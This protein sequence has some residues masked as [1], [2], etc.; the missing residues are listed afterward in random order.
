M[1]FL[2]VH[3][4][5]VMEKDFCALLTK[6]IFSKI[7]LSNYYLRVTV[8][9]YLQL[10]RYSMRIYILLLVLFL[11][12]GLYNCQEKQTVEGVLTKSL[13]S[14]NQIETINGE[15]SFNIGSPSPNSDL[16]TTSY[17]GK[18]Y[19][20][21]AKNDSVIGWY[22]ADDMEDLLNDLNY[23]SFY[24]GIQLTYFMKKD[25]LIDMHPAQHVKS[26]FTID[27]I[28]YKLLDKINIYHNKQV[29]PESAFAAKENSW[30]I[31]EITMLPDTN[32]AGFDCY[33]IQN[34]K[35]GNTLK[36]NATY[37]NTE[38]IAIDKKTH[39]PVYLYTH[40]VR[41]V[42]EE[43]QI[44]Q[45]CSF[46]IG[47]LH[48]N[49]PL[50][51]EL[52]NFNRTKNA[53]S[54]SIKND[55]K[56]LMQGDLLPNLNL[57]TVNED[58]VSLSSLKGQISILEFGYI[59]CG[60]CLLVSNELKKSHSTFKDHKNI[61]FYYINPIDKIARVKEYSKKENIPFEILIGNDHTINTLGIKSYPTV[62]IVDQDTRIN[63]IIN[64]YND[65]VMSNKLNKSI[66]SLINNRRNQ[67]STY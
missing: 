17:F 25:S 22:I 3:D 52:F 28:V 27:I 26:N 13:K 62:F 20:K 5:E 34:K 63:K 48:M 41:K 66:Y 56:E 6:Y 44:D 43:L 7:F 54:K 33:L 30:L 60:P 31:G 45:A 61:K 46:Q 10:Y 42:N 14:I 12:L 50:S 47:K 2:Q 36:F 51:D 57:Q 18:F 59:G 67:G 29:L 64:G 11:S 55:I 49:E 19:L 4:Y 21:R 9:L 23:Q 39:F 8:N 16:I 37:S 24:N 32:I 1:L 65:S 15:L 58:S 35:N 40:F 53:N 38:R